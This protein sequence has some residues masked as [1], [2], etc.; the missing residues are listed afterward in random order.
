MCKTAHF[1]GWRCGRGGTL[2]SGLT[3][4][5]IHVYISKYS[6]GYVVSRTSGINWYK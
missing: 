2:S 3:K 5:V 6:A 4:R 1:S